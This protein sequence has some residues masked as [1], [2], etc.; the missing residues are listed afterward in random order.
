VISPDRVLDCLGVRCPIPIIEAAKLI[1]TVPIGSVL[2]VLADD[3]AA[4]TDFPA[5]CRMRGHEYL[6][7]VTDEAGHPSYLIRRLT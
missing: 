7:E 1:A 2:V 6:G 4:R 3:P 5:W